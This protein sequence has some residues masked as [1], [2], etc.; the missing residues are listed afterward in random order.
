[1]SR[2]PGSARLCQPRQLLAWPSIEAD[3]AVSFEGG[4][5]RRGMA[6]AAISEKIMAAAML[7][8]QALRRNARKSYEN[9]QL[10]AS[11]RDLIMP[12]IYF[13]RE[14]SRALAASNIEA[15]AKYS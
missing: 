11:C 9:H 10:A 7:K 12:A 3:T 8:R 1:M 15:V 13:R 6:I 14:R 2:R 4:R 5:S